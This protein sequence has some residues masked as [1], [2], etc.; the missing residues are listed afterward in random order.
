MNEINT[1]YIL[2]VDSHSDVL[3]GYIGGAMFTVDILSGS[4]I[5]DPDDI[6][7]YPNGNRMIMLE[8]AGSLTVN[9]NSEFVEP[10]PTPTSVPTP[11]PEPTPEPTPTETPTTQHIIVGVTFP[12]YG[13]GYTVECTN[14]RTNEQMIFPIEPNNLQYQIYTFDFANYEFGWN[15]DDNIILS[16]NT[17]E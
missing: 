3:C 8:D 11:T 6:I 17:G 1:D 2:R 4:N 15:I 7:L 14:E 13:S 16:F 12:P 9:V 5:A 10:T